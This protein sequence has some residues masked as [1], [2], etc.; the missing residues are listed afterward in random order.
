MLDARIVGEN[1]AALRKAQGHS[2]EKLAELLHITPQAI[3]KWENGRSLPE[4]ALL[5][6]LAQ[7]FGRSIDELLLPARQEDLPQNQEERIA[8]RILSA[9]KRS[10]LSDARIRRALCDANGNTGHCTIARGDAVHADGNTLTPITVSAAQKQWNLTEKQ[11]KQNNRELLAYRLTRHRIR[12]IPQIYLLDA[13]GKIALTQDLH[14]DCIACFDYD[15]ENDAGD[16]IRANL[17]ALL[18][19]AASW[20][21]A[22]WADFDAFGQIGLDWRLESPEALAAHISGMERDY[23]Q[24][25]EKEEAG[26]IPRVW[27]GMENHSTPEMWGHYDAALQFLRSESAAW[28]TRMH[29]G[30]GVTVIHGDMH[31][32]AAFLSPAQGTVQFDGL[33]ALRM[34]LGAEDLA[35]LLALHLAPTRESALPLLRQYHDRLCENVRNYSFDA[36]LQDYRLAVAEALFFPIRLMNQGIFAFKMRDMAILAFGEFGEFGEFGVR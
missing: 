14:A 26:K 30:Q 21:G 28:L 2:Q 12:E 19:A 32:G 23:R 35:M 24:Y 33:Q 6:E 4:T 10:A 22:F 34:G 36:L 20:H 3:S 27:N 25:R 17:P 29:G 9:L 31:P 15:S 1:I 8:R 18:Q 16:A 7:I 11:Y 5:P 13:E